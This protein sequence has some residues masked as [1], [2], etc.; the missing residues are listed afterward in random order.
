ML[1]AQLLLVMM[2]VWLG[3]CDSLND[4]DSSLNAILYPFGSDEGDRK[5]KRGDDN[6]DG[7]ISLP[8]SVFNQHTMFVSS[9]TTP[10]NIINGC[11]S[12]Q[13]HT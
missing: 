7:P 1:C 3:R 12:E 2:S 10:V 8:V 5:V 6:C 11:R 4:S 13:L 9:D